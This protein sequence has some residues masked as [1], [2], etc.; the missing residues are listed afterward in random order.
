[1]KLSDSEFQRIVSYVKSNYGIVLDQKRVLIEGRLENYLIKHDYKSYHEY[2]NLVES[3]PRGKEAANLINVLT[4]NH[5][6]FM[7]ETEH[8]EFL[9]EYV[10]P[11]LRNTEWRTKDICTWCAAASSGEEAYTLA[12]ILKDYFRMVEGEWDTVLLATDISTRVLEF[13]YRGKY[14]REQIE[15]LPQAWKKCYFKRISEEEYMVSDELKKEVLF[16]QFNL[17]DPLP[18]RKKFHIV[19]LRN[20]MI[21]FDEQTKMKLINRIYEQMEVGGYLFI[22]I[23]ESID[24][25]KTKF[26]YVR[27]SV[28]QK[29]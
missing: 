22:G 9:R 25:S 13:A 23:T 12:M 2:M 24:R 10:L 21:Y 18:F 11:Q 29:I 3:N 15:P 4:T 19:F 14:L 26:R 6:Y 28:Y 7:R 8:F 16:R 20:V 17:M 1:M 27:P 5:T